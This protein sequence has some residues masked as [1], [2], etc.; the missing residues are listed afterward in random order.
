MLMATDSAEAE[1][2]Q[3]R[4]ELLQS[5]GL[6]ATCVSSREASQLEPALWLPQ[7]G[8]ALLLPTDAQL[9]RLWYK[10]L[11]AEHCPKLTPNHYIV[12]I[13]NLRL[14]LSFFNRSWFSSF[15]GSS[16]LVRRMAG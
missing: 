4:V 1:S 15:C 14:T 11:D 6:E 10:A 7:D 16:M 8:A 13:V 12:M 2:L 5:V 9:V 3:Q